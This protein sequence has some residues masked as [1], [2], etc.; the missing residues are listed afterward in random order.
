IPARKELTAGV[1][2]DVAALGTASGRDDRAVRDEALREQRS[3]VLPDRVATYVE[4]RSKSIDRAP[5][6]LG[7]QN[8]QQLLLRLPKL[9]ECM[10]HQGIARHCEDRETLVR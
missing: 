3:Q 8:A 7:L 6:A 5:V 10:T 9:L 2:Q 1:G 4:S